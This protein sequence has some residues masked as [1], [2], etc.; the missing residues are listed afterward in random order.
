[1]PNRLATRTL[2]MTMLAAVLLILPVKAQIQA[3]GGGTAGFSIAAPAAAPGGPAGSARTGMAGGSGAHRGH[4]SSRRSILFPYPYFD[5]D[6]SAAPAEPGPPQSVVGP[7]PA[8]PPAP[9]APLE[10]LLIEWQGDHFE[11]VT[12]SRKAS[13]VGSGAADSPDG[14]SP[15]ASSPRASSSPH[16]APAPGPKGTA[17][18]GRELPPAVLVFRDGRTEE[19]SSYTIMS[20]T[21]YSKADYWTSGSWTR[22]IPISDLDIT[23]TLEL[24]HH[25]GLNFVLPAGPNEIVTRP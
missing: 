19:I 16:G 6:Y 22:K 23:A 20:G 10:P 7:A 4:P 14:S 8:A 15:V 12:L 17:Q 21:I 5:S 18:P 25:H 11:R 2:A 3:A 9:P 1:M 24:N 13:T